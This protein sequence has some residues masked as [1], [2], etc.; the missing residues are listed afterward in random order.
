M[1]S[2]MTEHELSCVAEHLYTPRVALE[3][4]VV[5]MSML[6]SPIIDARLEPH[7]P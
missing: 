2:K 3:M 7:L 1:V 4:Q 6:S 5:L